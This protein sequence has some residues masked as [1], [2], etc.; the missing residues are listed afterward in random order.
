[1][2]RLPLAFVLV[3]SAI[4]CGSNKSDPTDA[5]QECAEPGEIDEATLIAVGCLL[6]GLVGLAQVPLY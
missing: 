6:G 5:L 4:A 1:M 3:A 2:N